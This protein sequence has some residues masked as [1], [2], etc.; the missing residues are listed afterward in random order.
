MRLIVFLALSLVLAACAKPAR[1]EKYSDEATDAKLVKPAPAS[2]A[3]GASS[4]ATLGVP[5][6]AYDYKYGIEA[7]AR[8]IRVLV[9]KHAAEC[10]AAGSQVCQMTG[11]NFDTADKGQLHAALFLRAT[12]QWIAGFRSRLMSDATADGGRLLQAT[13]T[14]EDL[15]RQI[16]DTE[17][18][19]KAKTE[20]RDRLL[21]VLASRP[22]K[23]ADLV[24]TEKALADLQEQ[25]DAANSELGMM[26]QRVAT[27]GLTIDYQT[28]D[29]PFA[30]TTWSPLRAALRGFIGT[31][32]SLQAFRR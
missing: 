4:S 27:S 17:A 30:Q 13:V 10:A 32:A 14:S 22:G 19:T 11:S 25:L 18:T 12:P 20:L 26:R 29:P 8:R 16:V 23:T 1:Y 15:S 24:E 21:S 3:T 7:S 5:L 9:S 2:P 28:Y 6:L 31:V